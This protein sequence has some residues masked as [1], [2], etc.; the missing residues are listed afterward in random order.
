MAQWIRV[1]DKEL[2]NADSILSWRYQK[3]IQVIRITCKDSGY[4]VSGVTLA[5]WQDIITALAAQRNGRY[6]NVISIPYLMETRQKSEACK[7][8]VEGRA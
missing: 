3:D 2:V 1:S 4:N 5:M 7:D 8:W 6:P